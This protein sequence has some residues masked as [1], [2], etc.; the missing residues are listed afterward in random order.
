MAIKLDF[1]T[2]RNCIDGELVDAKDHRH[3]INPS[4]LKALPDVPVST[5]E[6]L[7]KAVSGA[8]AAFKKWTKV[9]YEERRSAVMAFAAALEQVKEDF[10]RLLTTEQGK[11]VHLTFP[12]T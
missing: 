11:P 9:P 10:I 12:E 7:D 1:T 4:N 5:K 6:D 3:G 2:Y 8:R